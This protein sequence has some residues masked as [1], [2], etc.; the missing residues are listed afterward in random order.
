[1]Q[2]IVACNRS[3]F[4]ILWSTGALPEFFEP[5]RPYEKVSALRTVLNS[6]AAGFGKPEATIPLTPPPSSPR[7]AAPAP[8]SPMPELGGGCRCVEPGLGRGG[9]GF[10]RCPLRG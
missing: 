3:S 5:L 7:L 4:D 10:R 1:M 8:P 2:Y 9:R 6:A